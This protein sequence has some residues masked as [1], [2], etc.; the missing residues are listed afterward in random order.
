MTD[1]LLMTVPEVAHELRVSR[2]R[3][4]EMVRE[5]ELP[6]VRLGPH[7]LRVVAKDFA[8]WLRSRMVAQCV[9]AGGSR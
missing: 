2:R 8:E 5:G 3:A 1:A 4:Y 7:G 6:A 9:A